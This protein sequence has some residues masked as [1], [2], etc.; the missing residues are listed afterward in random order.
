V[1]LD[2]GLL[3]WLNTFRLLKQWEAWQAHGAWIR[4]VHPRLA[5]NIAA[6]F[7]IRLLD[8]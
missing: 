5:Q 1:R 2:G 8:H 6:S 4:A 3:P 7:C